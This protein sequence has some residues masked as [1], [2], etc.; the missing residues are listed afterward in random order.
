MTEITIEADVRVIITYT[1]ANPQRFG[2]KCKFSLVSTN[3]FLLLDLFK[4]PYIH[5]NII[6]VWNKIKTKGKFQ[7]VFHKQRCLP[8]IFP[9]I[10]RKNTETQNIRR[11]LN[12]YTEHISEGKENKYIIGKG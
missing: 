5:V 7:H 9:S 3:I 2:L 10:D 4:S 1:V 8:G 11:I 12:L 6:F